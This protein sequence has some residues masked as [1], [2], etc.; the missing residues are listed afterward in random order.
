MPAWLDP[1]LI[2]LSASTLAIFGVIATLWLRWLLRVHWRGRSLA[3][4]AR[5]LGTTIHRG[6]A[7]HVASMLP[8]FS[9][10]DGAPG[11][12]AY[13]TISFQCPVG[14]VRYAVV[15]GDWGVAPRSDG[16]DRAAGGAI[17]G[18]FL[19]ANLRLRK[20]PVII[21]VT[22]RLARR[23]QRSWKRRIL[24]LFHVHV[25]EA[26]QHYETGLDG[27]DLTY[28]V[29]T[30]DAAGARTLLTIDLLRHILSDP[31]LRLS[32]EGGWLLIDDGARRW[33]RRRFGQRLEWFE[34]FAQHWPRWAAERDRAPSAS[35]AA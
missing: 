34:R 20:L 7:P 24:S 19:A 25:S 27:F 2:P 15:M 31:P 14:E 11:R 33:S 29:Y 35:F 26:L 17:G 30:D 5:A 16:L 8:Q 28:A 12:A 9:P 1:V 22:R 6:E 10:R 18:S 13:N 3:R 4:V 23:L 21:I 32:I